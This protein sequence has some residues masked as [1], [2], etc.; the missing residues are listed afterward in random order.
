MIDEMAALESNQTW[1]LVPS[2]PMKSTVGC[3]WVF[4]VKVGPNGKIDRLKAHLVVKEYT[5][6]LGLIMEI[7]SL[8]LSWLFLSMAAMRNWPLYHLDI[9]IAFLH[10]DL[11]KEVYMEQPPRF[12]AQG[13]PRGFAQG[14]IRPY[15]VLSK[16]PEHGLAYSV[17]FFKS[18]P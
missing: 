16:A 1:T 11:A 4:T 8:Q 6:I 18:L 15:M 17:Q 2:P 13:E 12:V 10:S 3:R 5:H 9:K 7:I 14:Y